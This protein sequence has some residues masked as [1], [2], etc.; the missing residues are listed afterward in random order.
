MQLIE[1]EKIVMSENDNTKWVQY[2]VC[3]TKYHLK[4]VTGESEKKVEKE[5]FVLSWAASKH[6]HFKRYRLQSSKT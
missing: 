6:I 4:C 5:V 2:D 3:I 1:N